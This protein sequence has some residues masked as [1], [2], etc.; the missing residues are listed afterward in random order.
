MSLFN[1]L[2]YTNGVLP[3]RTSVLHYNEAGSGVTVSEM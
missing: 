1:V 2:C 3:A